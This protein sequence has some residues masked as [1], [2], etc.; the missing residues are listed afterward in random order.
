MDG[1]YRHAMT[2][3]TR[4]LEAAADLLAQSADADASTRAVCDAAGAPRRRSITIS[5]TTV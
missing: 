5:T 4:I 1:S 3:R 2:V